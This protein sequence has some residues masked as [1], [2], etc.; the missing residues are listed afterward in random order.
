MRPAYRRTPRHPDPAHAPV[1]GIRR[2][3]SATASLGGGG[4]FAMDDKSDIRHIT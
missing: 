4:S 3:A 1:P 2:S